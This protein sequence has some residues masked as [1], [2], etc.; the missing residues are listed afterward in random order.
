MRVVA[1]VTEEWLELS[2]RGEGELQ[3]EMNHVHRRRQP[4]F[5]GLADPG[6]L[7]RDI[8]PLTGGSPYNTGSKD[9]G[10]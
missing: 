2:V 5:P 8:S 10:R 3:C 4:T 6:L 7:A 9:L 1:E